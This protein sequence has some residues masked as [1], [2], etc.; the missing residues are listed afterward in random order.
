MRKSNPLTPGARAATYSRFSTGEQGREGLNSCETQDAINAEFATARGW[1]VVATYRDE[2]RTG[3]N[4]NRKGWRALLADA[5][6]GKFDVVVVTRMARLGRGDE[7]VI[8]REDLRR[9]GVTVA[10]SREEF[11]DGLG[12]YVGRA[13]TN[14]MDG[15][16]IHQIRDYTVDKLLSMIDLG[17]WPGGGACPFG[18]EAVEAS[19]YTAPGKRAPKRLRH[20]ATNA[21][22][23]REA[24]GLMVS[25]QSIASVGHWL[26]EVT[27]ESW[28]HSKT[29]RLL[30]CDYHAGVLVWGEVRREGWCEP[31]VAPEVWGE[32]QELL[33]TKRPRV[34]RRGGIDA[35]EPYYLAGRVRCACG[36]AM[37]PYWSKNNQGRVYRYYRCRKSSTCVVGE[38]PVEQVHAAVVGELASIARH[39]WRLRRTLEEAQGAPQDTS[40][41]TARLALLTRQERA[42][43]AR[44][45]RLLESIGQT[46]SDDLRADLIERA[47]AVR[48]E[49][50]A[51]GRER[52]TLRVQ[53][54]A[55][56]ISR[57]DAA[58]L[59]ATAQT[60]A[61]AW[62]H[63][64]EAERR[65]ILR[66]SVGRVTIDRHTLE[67]EILIGDPEFEAPPV[68]SSM[69][70]VV[71]GPTQRDRLT[72]VPRRATWR[73]ALWP[74]FV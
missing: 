56:Q 4:L 41:A 59:Q 3:R 42:A 38:A 43:D 65:E 47:E 8:A 68:G 30:S 21:P 44:Y 45:T 33:S 55:A 36:E 23:V 73:G 60:V 9:A 64:T 49:V 19:E 11:G 2:A 24:F 13:V 10:T 7:F 29:R 5:Q 57:P 20:H 31:I 16:Y 35:T 71:E 17:L 37:T 63:A 70:M 50:H 18:W 1:S 66:L 52:S 74:T 51:I 72:A 67:L 46:K 14:L 58:Q 27:G 12:G 22:I 48:A 54:D 62:P 26:A 53:I 40:E 28:S 61:Q 69:R 39:P 25:S 6:A 34:V 32:V 15:T